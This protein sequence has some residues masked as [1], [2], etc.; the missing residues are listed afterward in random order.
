MQ[1]VRKIDQCKSP[2]AQARSA[3]GLWVEGQVLDGIMEA[4]KCHGLR[5]WLRDSSIVIN[6]QPTIALWLTTDCPIR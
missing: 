6:K 4:T 3:R 5:T 1:L 2:Q